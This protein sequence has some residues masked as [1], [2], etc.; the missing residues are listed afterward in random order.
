MVSL[1]LFTVHGREL[2]L[3]MWYGMV[4]VNDQSMLILILV[5]PYVF[6]PNLICFQIQI[7]LIFLNMLFLISR[8]L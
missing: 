7:A 2:S 6:S 8:D 3:Q 4:S 1:N 5:Q